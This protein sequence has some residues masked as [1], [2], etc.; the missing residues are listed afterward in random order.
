MSAEINHDRRRF[1]GTQF[2][3]RWVSGN[4]WLHGRLSVPIGRTNPKHAVFQTGWIEIKALVFCGIPS[5]L[6]IWGKK[7]D[8]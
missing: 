5:R 6:T 1:L 8:G 4:A 2:R 7:E 3:I